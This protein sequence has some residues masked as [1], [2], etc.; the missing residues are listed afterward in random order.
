ME[1]WCRR[2]ADTVATIK[3]EEV[4]IETD[5]FGVNI[6]PNT[7]SKVRIHQK[8]IRADY[9]EAGFAIDPLDV[10]RREARFCKRDISLTDIIARHELVDRSPVIRTVIAGA[11]VEVDVIA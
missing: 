1:C 7:Y 11:E 3:S 9:R 8:G 5:R 2:G 4:L 10:G 6:G